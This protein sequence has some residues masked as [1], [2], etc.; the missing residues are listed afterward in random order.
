[1]FRIKNLYIFILKQN[2]ENLS[3]IYSFNY[4]IFIEKKEKK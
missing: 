3:V 4:I 2:S 1:M